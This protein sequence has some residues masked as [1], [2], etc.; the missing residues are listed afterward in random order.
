MEL[1]VDVRADVFDANGLM[2]S[3]ITR[4]PHDGGSFV[5]MGLSPG[6]YRLRFTAA[7]W[8]PAEVP[9][10]KI[11]REGAVVDL[12]VLVMRRDVWARALSW[13]GDAPPHYG[14]TINVAPGGSFRTR[15][16]L[17][18]GTVPGASGVVGVK[19]RGPAE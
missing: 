17:S 4:T 3:E 7:G 6:E 9:E 10:V 12:G 15:V 19:V 11:E 18:G 5:L 14:R 1:L 2:R 8:E 13:Y 16:F